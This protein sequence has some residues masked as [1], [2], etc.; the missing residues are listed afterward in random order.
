MLFDQ[1]SEYELPFKNI[2]YS[3][4]CSYGSG[5]IRGSKSVIKLAE[6]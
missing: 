1:P 6:R 2:L 3:F 5:L 4:K